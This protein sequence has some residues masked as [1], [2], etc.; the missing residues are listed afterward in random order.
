M[1]PQAVLRPQLDCSLTVRSR[2]DQASH[3]S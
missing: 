1:P 3:P 2:Q